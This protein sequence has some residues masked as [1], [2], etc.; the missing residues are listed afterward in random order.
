MEDENSFTESISVKSAANMFGG[1]AIIRRIPTPSSKRRDTKRIPPPVPARNS[2]RTKVSDIADISDISYPKQNVKNTN[3]SKNNVL[4]VHK[5]TDLSET[6]VDDILD[7]P[8]ESL[9]EINGI[10]ETYDNVDN[11]ETIPSYDQF[12]SGAI[13]ENLMEE[14]GGVHT[15]VTT[16]VRS[17]V[18]N[19]ARVL[20]NLAKTTKPEYAS[21]DYT[22]L[23]TISPLNGR[24]GQNDNSKEE[25][26]LVLGRPLSPVANDS[27][28]KRCL[29]PNDANR[30]LSPSSE[31]LPTK[32]VAGNRGRQIP[33][34]SP[35]TREQK[36]KEITN[37]VSIMCEGCNNCLLDLKRQAL[38]L[39]YPDSAHGE[40]IA[41]PVDSIESFKDKLQVPENGYRFS[42]VGSCEVCDTHVTQLKQEA[43]S[44]VQSIQQAQCKSTVPTNIPNLIGS[45]NLPPQSSRKIGSANGPHIRYRSSKIPGTGNYLSKSAPIAAQAQAYLEQNVR[46]RGTQKRQ[47]LLRSGSQDRPGF[48][49]GPEMYPQ[50]GT[51]GPG[52]GQFGRPVNYPMSGSHFINTPYMQQPLSMQVYH[53]Q[54]QQLQQ[55]QQQQFYHPHQQQQFHHQQQQQQQQQ[56]QFFQQQHHQPPIQYQPHQYHYL[57]HSHSAP[58]SP[59]RVLSPP[60]RIQ[61]PPP[62]MSRIAS[63]PPP[64]PSMS[65][66]SA[67]SP[68]P[69]ASSSPAASFFARAAQKLSKKKKRHHPP[70]PELPSFPTKFSEIIRL[71]SPPCPPCLL[72]NSA[73]GQP[74]GMGKVKVM[75]RVVSTNHHGDQA[76]SVLNIDTRNKQVTVY[77]PAGSGYATSLAHRKAAMAPKMFAFDSVFSPDDCLTEVCSG[78]LPE[79]I[80]GVVTGADGCVFTYGYSKLGKT[81]TMVGEDSTSQTLGVI[82]CAISWL[83]KV[84]NEQKDQTGARFSVR[85]SAVEVSGKQEVLKDLLADVAQGT[86]TGVGTAPGVYLREDPISGTQLENQ[87]ELRAPT[88][89]KAA[90]YLDAALNSRTRTEEESRSS[91]LLFTLHVYQYRIEKENRA[92]LP[93]VAGGRSRLHLIDL[94]SAS[95]SKDPNN[96]ALSLS[97][98][99]NVIMALLNGQRHVPHRDSKVAQLLRDSLGNIT[100]RTCMIAHVSQ[101]IPHYNESLQVIQLAARIHRM[102]RRKVRGQFSGTSSD[103]SSTDGS[104][105]RSRPYRGFRMG[106]LHEGSSFSDP[107]YTSS[108]ESCNT[109]IYVGNTTQQS[110]SDRE[111]TDH[112]GHQR[113]V[114]RTNPRLPRRASGSRSSGD[115]GS[116]SDSGR[117]LYKS[118]ESLS[119]LHGAITSPVRDVSVTGSR[120][121]TPVRSL[122]R[123]TTPV[124]DIQTADMN[125]SVSCSPPSVHFNLPQKVSSRSK[126]LGNKQDG[127]NPQC[128]AST[129]IVDKGPRTAARPKRSSSS[130]G[131]K[132]DEQWIDGPGAAIYPE[133]KQ[134]TGEQWVDGPSAFIVK[135]EQKHS[136][137]NTKM[138]SEE[139]WVD[140]PPEMLAENQMDENQN[141]TPKVVMHTSSKKAHVRTLSSPPR[142]QSPMNSPALPQKTDGVTPKQSW[143]MPDIKER[144]ESQISVE[145]TMSNKAQPSDS[146]PNSMLTNVGDAE[147]LAPLENM[148]VK[149]FVKDWVEKHGMPENDNSLGSMIET[150]ENLTGTLDSVPGSYRRPKPHDSRTRKLM[151][152]SSTPKQSPHHSPKNSPSI[153]RKVKASKPHFPAPPSTS[154]RVTDWLKSVENN[155]PEETI[156]MEGIVGRNVKETGMTIEHNNEFEHHAASLDASREISSCSSVY[157]DTTLNDSRTPD[158]TDADLSISKLSDSPNDC[159]I[160]DMSFDSSVDTANSVQNR[161]SIYELQ[162]DEQLEKGLENSS[163]KGDDDDDD[164]FSN[165]SCA[166]LSDMDTADAFAEGID[167]MGD[168]KK[169]ETIQSIKT[170]VGDSSVDCMRQEDTEHFENV[171]NKELRE[172]EHLQF[173]YEP[174]AHL[175]SRKPDGAS[176][177]N[178]MCESFSEK[179]N[180]SALRE[181]YLIVNAI[182][183]QSMDLT[184]RS[185]PVSS[186]QYRECEG[187]GMIDDTTD[188]QQFSPA[189]L[190]LKPCFKCGYSQEVSKPIAKMCKDCQKMVALSIKNS[191]TSV[192][193]KDKDKS[194]YNVH[195]S[196][197][198]GSPTSKG[199]KSKAQSPSHS[200]LPVFSKN[201]QVSSKDSKSSRKKE[202]ESKKSSLLTRKS[203]RSH[204]SDSGNDSGIVAIEKTLLSPYATVT[205]PRT[206]SHSS[207]GHGSDNSS[208]MSADLISKQ[209]SSLSD[210]IHGG[211]SSGYE[212]MLRE[213]EGSGSSTINEDSADESSGDKKKATKKKRLPS[214]RRSRSAPSRN[215]ESPESSS[216]KSSPSSKNSSLSPTSKAWQEKHG[217]LKEEGPLEL[218]EYDAEDV[219]RMTRHRTDEETLRKNHDKIKEILNNGKQ[220]QEIPNTKDT[221]IVDRNNWSFDSSENDENSGHCCYVSSYGYHRV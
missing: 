140:G 150:G 59:A 73:R 164:S 210:K 35:N 178:L 46:S 170:L 110:L 54:Q 109:V 142:H 131:K 47:I 8:L 114:P 86:E 206:V 39:I 187:D 147:D 52:M 148:E 107:D 62:R 75:L 176:N 197:S 158:C 20:P 91:H 70:E 100:C 56:Q 40:P 36:L 179:T 5:V 119:R 193:R 104:S 172:K 182:S 113:S 30:P 34:L 165:A 42:H 14:G 211:T 201:L 200:K 50:G 116:N 92:G 9:S 1:Q 61:S 203:S 16:D 60:P 166:K 67:M 22:V 41:M 49:K 31:S 190:P 126:T 97:A 90:F 19:I 130:P 163:R 167:N 220:S 84:I 214:T 82:P 78:S 106:T 71:S 188:C 53:Q 99:G 17:C 122:S 196:S 13:G 74:P 144:P 205:K 10:S 168:M 145:S 11:D 63:P 195:P 161:D 21:M 202:K 117:S 181:E 38:R 127:S 32:R 174:I 98:L 43:V 219:K 216:R 33:V 146:R 66:L 162:M 198:S 221:Y 183:S 135:Q 3:I 149:P 186:K 105:I 15:E 169:S 25:M 138:S 112:E 88:A 173:D 154:R 45:V 157:P 189:P 213:S 24:N 6:N 192:T 68:P 101:E 55:Q 155:K 51:D 141:R 152:S 95:K 76:A 118:R 136:K 194:K 27:G 160:A 111:L 133:K 208:T 87:S 139:M 108:S 72:R 124:R 12:I 185:H 184:K 143:Q 64:S 57:Q 159:N 26:S 115:E 156:Y 134:N 7:K 65:R 2:S 120:H 102:R 4:Q 218:K 123:G 177:P 207:S 129:N 209:S 180:V 28:L 83:F 151:P 171:C 191:H 18:R 79:I 199:S 48:Y 96:V 44:M 81:Y 137:P 132:G 29:S 125:S 58:G 23:G 80:Q 85:V 93:G 121:G 215:S 217:R 77:D 212:S 69:S 204:D 89:E 153:H 37:H 128:Y 103:D 175:L 94:G